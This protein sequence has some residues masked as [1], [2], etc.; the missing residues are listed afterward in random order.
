MGAVGLDLS[1]FSLRPAPASSFSASP[2]PRLIA[3][4]QLLKRMGAYRVGRSVPTCAST[5]FS[6][7][8]LFSPGSR[9]IC[10]V[11]ACICFFSYLRRPDFFPA[12]SLQRCEVFLRISLSINVRCVIC[13]DMYKPV[14][15]TLYR[16]ENS[17]TEVRAYEFTSPL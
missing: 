12:P 9:N 13:R 7:N 3:S 6:R 4:F 5:S 11:F 15:A 14:S 8:I 2:F 10:K 1:L 17:Y 16:F